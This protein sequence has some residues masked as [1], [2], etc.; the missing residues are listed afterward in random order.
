MSELHLFLAA[1][2]VTG[3]LFRL[4]VTRFE[5]RHLLMAWDYL[6]RQPPGNAAHDRREVML[7]RTTIALGAARLGRLLSLLLL[8]PPFV[9][10]GHYYLPVDGLPTQWFGP[11]VG[12]LVRMALL[13]CGLFFVLLLMTLFFSR[14]MESRRVA[15]EQRPIP[16][17][18]TDAQ[19]P[20]PAPIAA[21]GILW[22]WIVRSL[23][24]VGGGLI[25]RRPE[26]YLYEHEGELFMA[27]GAREMG[28]LDEVR[29]MRDIDPTG[30][31]S[32]AEMVRSI[33]RL[34]VT[35]VREVMRPLNKVSAVSLNGLTTEKFLQIARRTGYT[36]FP[37]Y[38]DQVTNLIGYLNVHDFLD[39][40]VPPRDIRKLVLPAPFIPELARIDVAL[41]EMLRSKSQIAICFDEFGGCSGLLSR[42]D[43]LEEITGEIMD[44]Y[45]RPDPDELKI[46][47]VRDH[48]LVDAATDLDELH[49]VVGI[50]LEKR[51]ADTI[52]GYIY[53]R[54]SRIPRRGEVLE[55]R[56]WRIEVSRLDQHRIRKV[57]LFP[58]P[59]ENPAGNG[60]EA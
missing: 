59:D 32:E 9:I 8:L 28:A 11:A 22:D 50:E 6:T 30:N 54:L 35:I 38:Y 7:E 10:L 39:S 60:A 2:F 19:E 40:V 48:Y 4:L 5:A 13:G 47:K 36:R 49:E 43:I 45:D 37:C 3:L 14:E 57:K 44:E 16:G 26:A 23:Q 55:E 12:S 24:W 33:Q 53:Q 52:A 20:E 41:E 15:S 56:G 1:V 25:A 21:A 31:K 18:L 29:L 17:W 42:E 46:Q 27:I 34:S 58:P 51:N